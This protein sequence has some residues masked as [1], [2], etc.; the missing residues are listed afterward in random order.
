[1]GIKITRDSKI[2][3]Q[4]RVYRGKKRLFGTSECPRLLFNKTLRFLYAQLIDDVNK[5]TLF[6]CSTIGAKDMNEIERKYNLKNLKVA[7]SFGK[8]VGDILKERGYK[9]IVFDRN[10][11]LYHGKVKVFA[12][13]IREQGI[14]F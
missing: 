5:K 13:A 9:S 14:N 4:V 3:K 8:K 10:G 12:D 1:M 2:R 6:S 7:S 11:Y